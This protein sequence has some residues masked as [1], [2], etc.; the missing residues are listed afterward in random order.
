MLGR[1]MGVPSS[2]GTRVR[3]QQR[4]AVHELLSF[5]LGSL[6]LS[7]GSLHLQLVSLGFSIEGLGCDL[8]GRGRA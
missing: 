7:P 3:V 6:F 4:P 2:I 5:Y 8:V 1:A